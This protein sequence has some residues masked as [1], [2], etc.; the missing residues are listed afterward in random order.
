VSVGHVVACSDVDNVAMS[1]PVVFSQVTNCT[2]V[3]FRHVNTC[4]DLSKWPR[5]YKQ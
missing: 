4:S 3:A 5:H 1:L 2:E